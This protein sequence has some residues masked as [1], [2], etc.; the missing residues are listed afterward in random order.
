MSGNKAAV[1]KVV[2]Q[3]YSHPVPIPLPILQDRNPAIFSCPL[4]NGQ[5]H[6]W[7]WD[8]AQNYPNLEKSARSPFSLLSTKR[9]VK[10]K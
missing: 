6:N 9:R 1:P 7:N 3:C 8:N 10:E 4:P 5:T 2:N